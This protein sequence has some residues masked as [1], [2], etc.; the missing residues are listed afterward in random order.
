MSK[1]DWRPDQED[2]RKRGEVYIRILGNLGDKHPLD[3]GGLIVYEVLDDDLEYIQAEYW[4][5]PLEENRPYWVYRFDIPKDVFRDLNWVSGHWD[6]IAQ[7]AGMSTEALFRMGYSEDP[8][9]RAEVYRL[10]GE[11]EGW[12]N[13]DE[14]PEKL[15]REEMEERWPEYA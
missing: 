7:F 1:K 5:E 14:Y 10:V 6:R 3:Y 8:L 12:E 4:N 11:H 9:E 15:S 13:I 2:R